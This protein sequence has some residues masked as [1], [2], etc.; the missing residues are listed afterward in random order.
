MP[1][2]L[3]IIARALPALVRIIAQ[4]DTAPLNPWAPYIGGG[5]F[6]A[7]MSF[8]WWEERKE[9]KESQERERLTYKEYSDR[10]SKEVSTLEKTGELLLA[11]RSRS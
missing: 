2:L 1:D 9:R 6:S 11:R 10:I 7:V 8:L 3:L 5:S 4:A